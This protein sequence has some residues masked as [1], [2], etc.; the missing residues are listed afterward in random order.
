MEQVLNK[1]CERPQIRKNVA[2]V[3]IALESVTAD[4]KVE[5]GHAKYADC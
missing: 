2:K 1:S 3:P 4:S 5:T